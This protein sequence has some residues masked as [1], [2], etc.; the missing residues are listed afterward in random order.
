MYTFF[1]Y[2][3]SQLFIYLYKATVQ[4][5]PLHMVITLSGNYWLSLCTIVVPRSTISE[6]AGSDNRQLS[7]TIMTLY[8]MTSHFIAVT[9]LQFQMMAFEENIILCRYMLYIILC[10]MYFLVLQE[11]KKNHKISKAIK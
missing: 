1:D 7:R 11:Y 4:Q 10:T 2:I 8:N 6:L 5:N 3:F 9:L